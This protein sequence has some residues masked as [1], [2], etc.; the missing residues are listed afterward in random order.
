MSCQR[1]KT[2]CLAGLWILGGIGLSL[3]P[4]AACGESPAQVASAA[5][6]ASSLVIPA[7]AYDRGTGGLARPIRRRIV[8]DCLPASSAVAVSAS[9]DVS[10]RLRHGQQVGR[11]TIVL[12]A[13]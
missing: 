9:D 4:D 12:A 1:V 13:S 7:Y 6:P 8:C 10:D 3:V 2:C 11:G 5:K